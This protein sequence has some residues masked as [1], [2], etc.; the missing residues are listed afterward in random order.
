M[1]NRRFAGTARWAKGR[2]LRAVELVG[3]TARHQ[4]GCNT[5]RTDADAG[6]GNPVDA[7]AIGAIRSQCARTDMISTVRS[8][9]AC[10]D[11]VGTVRSHR[12]CT[13]MVGAIGRN[14]SCT[15]MIGT[16]RS[17]C[18]GTDMVGAI[19]RNGSCTYMIGTIRSDCTGTDMISPIRCHRPGTH[20][21]R[22]VGRQRL[23]L[24]RPDIGHHN[25]RHDRQKHA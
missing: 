14:G 6:I 25:G 20:M 7:S 8:H 11:M 18:T 12:A 4:R 5:I 2:L 21:I 19:G 22:P 10:T 9:G 24:R 1:L 3:I 23:R 17:D 13:D 15:Y 16:I